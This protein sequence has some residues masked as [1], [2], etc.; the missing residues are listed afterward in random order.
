MIDKKQIKE[1]LNKLEQKLK[2]KNVLSEEDLKIIK[3]LELSN[4]EE[5][6]NQKI[7]AYTQQQIQQATSYQQIVAARQAFIQKKLIQKQQVKQKK[8]ILIGLLLVSL[9]IIGGTFFFKGKNIC[10]SV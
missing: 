10:F 7:D 9:L 8:V 6:F 2:D 5:L 3:Q 1:A 4:L